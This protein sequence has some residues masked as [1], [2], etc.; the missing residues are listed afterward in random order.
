MLLNFDINLCY[1]NLVLRASI[2]LFTI[3]GI[4][5][6]FFHSRQHWT[7]VLI[8]KDLIFHFWV[9]KFSQVV[10]YGENEISYL[11]PLGWNYK[12]E[13]TLKAFEMLGKNIKITGRL[14]LMIQQSCLQFVISKTD[15]E[16]H[17]LQSKTV[18]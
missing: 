6:L 11:L 4:L 12:K 8:S 1:K 18:Y 2:Y 3:S 17:I 14:S 15:S 13:G 9:I 16:E 7:S 10:K 5:L